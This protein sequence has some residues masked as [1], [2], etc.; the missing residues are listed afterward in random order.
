ME[1]V[2]KLIIL[3]DFYS[4]PDIK[5]KDRS[6]LGLFTNPNYWINTAVSKHPYVRERLI[7]EYKR[8]IK[9]YKLDGT[10]QI[11]KCKLSDK[12]QQMIGISL[13]NVL[14]PLSEM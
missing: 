10:K 13:N 7:R 8:L 12:F 9:K 11:I 4:R 3:D 2:D 6:R 14:E 1:Q 5:A